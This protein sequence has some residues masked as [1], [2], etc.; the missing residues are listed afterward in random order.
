MRA[1]LNASWR[2][3][4]VTLP[5]ELV[6][7]SRTPKRK[8]QIKTPVPAVAMHPR[9][10]VIHESQRYHLIGPLRFDNSDTKLYSPHVSASKRHKVIV[11]KGSPINR[12]AD[13]EGTETTLYPS[14]D[15]RTGLLAFVW[16][17]VPIRCKALHVRNGFSTETRWTGLTPHVVPPDGP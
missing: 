13:D 4:Q 14:N 1:I 8:T 7:Q 16:L 5:E 2:S 10:N 6:E 17:Y 11:V 9:K 15:G 3:L 12:L